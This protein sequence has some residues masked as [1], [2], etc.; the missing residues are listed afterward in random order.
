MIQSKAAN[1]FTSQVASVPSK[2]RY[3]A[4]RGQ[5]VSLSLAFQ[6]DEYL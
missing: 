6:N 1:F 2:L 4:S 3:I 5:Q